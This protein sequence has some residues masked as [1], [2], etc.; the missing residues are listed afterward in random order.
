MSLIRSTRPPAVPTPPRG[1][2]I[3]AYDTYLAAQKAV[4]HLSD[5][6]FPVQHVTIVGTDLRMVERV[7][8]RLTY[9]RVALAGL[10]SGA[11]FGLFVGILLSFFASPTGGGSIIFPA[12]AIG[13]AFGILFSVISYAFTGGKRDFTSASQIVAS[14]YAVLCESE[15]AH[16][17]R[18][19]LAE[20]GGGRPWPPAATPAAPP[21][22]PQ[23]Q[24]P[25][26][27]GASTQPQAPTPPP[28][29]AEPPGDARG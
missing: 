21:T 23:H 2:Q 12:I 3:A 20:L 27:P 9:S 8:G 11:W 5:K 24:Q 10:A 22:P 18:G 4:D 1:E 25:T 19:L 17:A 6:E 13:A 26:Q 7:T 28:P 15:H 29:P 14:Q 16:K